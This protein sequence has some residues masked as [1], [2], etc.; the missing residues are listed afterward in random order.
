ME[1]PAVTMRF[2][3]QTVQ[4]PGNAKTGNKKTKHKTKK[5]NQT[6][7]QQQKTQNFEMY[8]EFSQR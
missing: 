4:T 7:E 8:V 3:P 6:K 5:P 1:K 2:H